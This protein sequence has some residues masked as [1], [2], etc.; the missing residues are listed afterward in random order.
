MGRLSFTSDDA[1]RLLEA[2]KVIALAAHPRHRSLVG[3]IAGEAVR[4]SWWGHPKGHDIFAVATAL[5]DRA[6]VLC[7][8]VVDGRV[9]FVHHD[10]FAPLLRVLTDSGRRRSQ[11]AG[12]DAVARDLLARVR[13]T[14]EL[15]LDGATPAERKARGKLDERLLV[16][17]GQLHTASGKHVAVLRTWERW[18]A[19]ETQV[20]AAALDYETAVTALERAGL[21][22]QSLRA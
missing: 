16:H 11:T 13:R 4:G 7:A 19:P 3:E 21:S 20:L 12:L 14:G 22:R 15:T 18:A 1:F 2:E 6:D 9:A 17:S 8:K 5:A 10:L